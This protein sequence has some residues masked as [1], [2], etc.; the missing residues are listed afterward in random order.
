MISNDD[1]SKH[2]ICVATTELR[3]KRCWRRNAT[4][5]IV[6]AA[7]ATISSRSRSHRLTTVAQWAQRS[8]RARKQQHHATHTR[9]V[10]VTVQ[11][12]YKG[13]GTA[14]S[15]TG[16]QTQITR[17]SS[18]TVHT[19]TH[20]HTLTLTHSLT[21]SLILVFQARRAGSALR[22]GLVE[23]RGGVERRRRRWRRPQ[24][25][26]GVA[27]A[28]E[29]AVRRLRVHQLVRHP[30]H[31]EALRRLMQPEVPAERVALF[32]RPSACQCECE[33][34]KRVEPLLLLLRPQRIDSGRAP[35]C[36]TVF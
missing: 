33:C 35:Q 19:H 24:L 27:A 15:T 34:E 16:T 11:R 25:A 17:T 36:T 8:T 18:R 13:A 21:H 2:C 22:V 23:R 29:V 20:T 10:T 31:H 32:L 6:T 4:R 1:R 30:L 3:A 7:A 28:R 14:E 12:V 9:T 5:A 26:L